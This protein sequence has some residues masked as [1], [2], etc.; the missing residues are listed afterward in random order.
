MLDEGVGLAERQGLKVGIVVTAVFVHLVFDDE[1]FLRFGGWFRSF[2]F[3]L[4]Y[5][6]ELVVGDFHGTLSACFCLPF[7]AF[8]RVKV[9]SC[10]H[11]CLV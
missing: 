1:P 11:C 9:S 3:K 5:A 4:V 2:G 7:T 6:H 10:S 8:C